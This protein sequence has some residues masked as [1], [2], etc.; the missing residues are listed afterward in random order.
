M[1]DGVGD[2]DSAAIDASV[3]QRVV[4]NLSGRPDK[5]PTQKIL[6]ITRL[7]ADQHDRRMDR[8][9]AEHDLSR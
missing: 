3:T 7:L 4:E 2:I 8:S 6:L 9:L 5:W 1:L